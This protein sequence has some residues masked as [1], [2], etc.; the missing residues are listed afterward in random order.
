MKLTELLRSECIRVG[1]T[2]DDKAM[3]LC[4]IAALAKQSGIL[5][6]IPE[7]M[8]LEALQE[9][10]TLGTT[11]FGNGIAI[12]HCRME[13]IHD[14][15]VGLLT[16]PEGVEFEAEDGRKV[17]LLVFIIAPKKSRNTHIRLLSAISQACQDLSAVQAMIGASDGEQLG[18]LFLRAARQEVSEQVSESRNLIQVFVRDETV[19]REIVETLSGLENVSLTVFQGKPGSTYLPDTP[20]Y[21]EF[22]KSESACSRRIETITGSLLECTGV[23][24]TIQ[25]LSYSAGSLEM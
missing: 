23:M 1:S 4:E 15:V 9:R 14:F 22:A 24:V 11:A 3:A 13:G 6:K 8:V 17:H 10:E 5:K 21:A 18:S 7:E 2:V 12:P 19:F 25:K 16:V 20:L